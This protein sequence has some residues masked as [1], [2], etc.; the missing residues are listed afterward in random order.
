MVLAGLLQ[1]DQV[2]GDE[3]TPSTRSAQRWRHRLATERHYRPYQPH[4][5]NRP[6]GLVGSDRFLLLI[7]RFAYPRAT[8]AESAALIF[9]NSIRDLPRL[10]SPS[11]ITYA[12][13]TLGLYEEARIFSG[14]SLWVLFFCVFLLF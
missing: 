11:E 4:G 10:Y 6:V 14:R 12:E 13:D 9:Q 3:R 2:N 5:N 1:T 8:A 7:F